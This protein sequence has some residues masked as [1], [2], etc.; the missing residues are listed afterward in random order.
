MS[1]A[2]AV[3]SPL[4]ALLVFLAVSAVLVGPARPADGA[5][6]AG[7][8]AGD[9]RMNEIQVKGS[10][11]SY[12]LEPSQ[13]A[14]DLMITVRSDAYLLQ[15][16]HDPLAVQLEEQGVRQVEL[17][18][19]ADPVGEQY[20]PPQGVPGFKVL[21]IEQV[22]KGSNCPLFTDC[23]E[24]MKAWSDQHP[25]HVPIAVLLELK[26]DDEIPGGPNIPA[27]ID[28]ARLRDLDDEIRS[29]LPEDRLITPDF[30]RGVGRPGGADGAGTVYPDVESAVLGY[31]WPELGDVRGRFVF[32]LDNKR[33]EYLD[34]DATLSGRVAFP[35]SSPGNPDAGFIKL[36]NSIG[37][38]DEIVS[39]IEAGYL[40]RTRAD[41]P[42]ET[43]L[44]GDAS[45]REAAL[46]SGAQFVSGDYLKPDDYARYD[47]TFAARYDLPF[48]PARPAYETIVPGGTPARC[49]PRIA[50]VGCLSGDVEDLEADETPVFPDVPADHVFFQDI[51]WLSGTGVT[52]GFEDGSYRPSQPV[53]RGSMAA[54]LYRYAGEPA[55]D[56]PDTPTFA[57]VP[58]T[59]PFF[60]EI[61]WAASKGITTGF[62]DDTFRPGAVITRGSMAAFLYR[63]AGEPALVPPA[64]PTFSDVPATH[65]FGDEIEWAAL[66]GVADGF[67]DGSYRPADAVGRGAFAAFLHRFDIVT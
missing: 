67:E 18:L 40:V 39:A 66:V 14:I 4:T 11:N 26:D 41:Y 50:P 54:F 56:A 43:G 23:L 62:T 13:A 46:S 22:D 36:N 38:Y 5:R 21:H 37:D 59:H 31:G 65:I 3:R 28:A 15:Y 42:V 12:H 8:A 52:G 61:E 34:G 57:D 19:W 24:Q 33:S 64:E 9:L 58:A 49:N 44:S 51:Q 10:H 25:T 27:P 47:A 53:T 6:D 30:V 60:R 63:T 17:D 16:S 1:N 35:P 45:D 48:D 2:H 32:L 55:F 7:R 29:V 20:Y